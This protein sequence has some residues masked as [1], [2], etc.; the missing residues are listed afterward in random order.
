MTT[1]GKAKQPQAGSSYSN[2]YIAELSKQGLKGKELLD[3]LNAR[4]FEFPDEVTV[5]Y[6]LYSID[7]ASGK[8]NWNREFHSGKPPGGRHRKNSFSSETPVTDGKRVYVYINNL[9]LFAYDL[10]GNKLW[11]TPLESFPTI[12]ALL[13]GGSTL[14]PAIWA[15]R[16]SNSSISLA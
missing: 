4:D 10:S 3:R 5:H 14:M 6:F 7:L 11:N 8:V 15:P 16:P 2:D 12:L 1:D 13:D 9:G